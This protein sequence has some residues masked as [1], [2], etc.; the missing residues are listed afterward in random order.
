VLRPGGV[1]VGIAFNRAATVLGSTLANTLVGRLPIV[2]RIVD[3]GY[4]E[5]NDRVSHCFYHTESQLRTEFA[6][7]GLRPVRIFGL[8]GPGGWLA[9]L[10][11]AH[12]KDREFSDKLA[13]EEPFSTALAACRIADRMPEL[14]ACSS[15]FLAIGRKDE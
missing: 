13:A 10:I 5:D 9:V 4:S 7:A 2:E 11:D 8:T 1:A 6:D 3:S 15:V 12:F 14:I